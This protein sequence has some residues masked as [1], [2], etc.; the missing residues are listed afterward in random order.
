MTNPPVPPADIA[1]GM[2]NFRAGIVAV[3]GRANVG[4][5]SLINAILGEK[6]SIVSPVVQTTRHPVRGIW[7]DPRGQVVLLDTPGSHAAPTDIGKLM[8]RAARQCAEGAD[9]V[10]LVLDAHAPPSIEDEGWMRRLARSRKDQG[11]MIA[12]NKTDA[13][14]EGESALRKIWET[15]AAEFQLPGDAV[16]WW[17]VSATTGEGLSALCDEWMKRLPVHPPL[18]PPDVLT[19]FP[20]R[21]FI[22]DIIREKLIPRLH[23]ELPHR[24]AAVVD[25]LRE[26]PDG[27]WTVDSRILVDRGSQVG[28]VVGHKGRVLRAVR[29]AAEAELSAIYEHPVTLNIHVVVEPNW[30]RNFFLLKRLGLA[31]AG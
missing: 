1:P 26:E 29:R 20:R 3:V 9:D 28:I 12:L 18:F 13:G 8:N 4:K 11:W 23:D 30:T 21:L 24:V 6:I 14:R 19:D 15:I 2:E 31:G 27:S 5:S 16:T 22:G 7:N 17:P 10:L 25:E